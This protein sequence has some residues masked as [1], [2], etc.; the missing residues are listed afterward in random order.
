MSKTTETG[1]SAAHFICAGIEVQADMEHEGTIEGE[2]LNAA[3]LPIVEKWGID[4]VLAAIH[5]AA[6]GA[7]EVHEEAVEEGDMT[8]FRLQVFCGRLRE[9]MEALK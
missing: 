7:A 8:P 6:L 2:Y 3:L 5:D 4:Q 9:A 1:K